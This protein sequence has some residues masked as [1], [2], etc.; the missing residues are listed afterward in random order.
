MGL[1]SIQPGDILSSD[2]YDMLMR[3]GVWTSCIAHEPPMITCLFVVST[4]ECVV[5]MVLSLRVDINILL[6]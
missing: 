5:I 2:N 3:F 6:A 1:K 4:R